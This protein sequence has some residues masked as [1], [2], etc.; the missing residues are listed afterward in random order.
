LA[1]VGPALAGD[2]RPARRDLR[3][4]TITFVMAAAASGF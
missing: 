3:V 4:G 1:R 2:T